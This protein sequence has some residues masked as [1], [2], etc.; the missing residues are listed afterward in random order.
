MK[1]VKV[2]FVKA[3]DSKITQTEVIFIE[4]D[5]DKYEI[6][7]H[8]EDATLNFGWVI[9]AIEEIGKSSRIERFRGNWS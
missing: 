5:V 8:F 9:T 6:M 1:I 2:S 7:T 4:D 3:H